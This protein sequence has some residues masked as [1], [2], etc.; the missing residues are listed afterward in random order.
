MQ[1]AQSERRPSSRRVS[2]GQALHR[3]TKGD[4]H[5]GGKSIWSECGGRTERGLE[6]PAPLAHFSFV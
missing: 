4:E 2:I 5:S 3:K 1:V 6:E